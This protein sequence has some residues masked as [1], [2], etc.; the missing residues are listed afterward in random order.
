MVVARYNEPVLPLPW[1]LPADAAVTAYCKGRA[2]PA[3]CRV[4]RLPNVG[5]C[6]HT[7]LH[8][9]VTRYDSLA[10]VT[11]FLPGSWY[12]GVKWWLTW[13]VVAFAT[14][15]RAT[16]LPAAPHAGMDA[17]EIGTWHPSNPHNREAGPHTL[18]P[19][20]P[21]PFGRWFRA[22]F[23]GER[24]GPVVF[25]GIFAATA[26]DIRR[27]PRHFYEGL[28]RQLDHHPRPAAGHYCERAW[29]T[30]LSPRGPVRT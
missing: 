17:F 22:N 27:R 20:V 9:I 3:G 7:Y 4:V 28:L 18:L 21:S 5:L 24:L 14:A 30:I 19:A 12:Q 25:K 8:H 1:L 16:V 23:P 26:A 13:G 29:G 10:P 6:D 11:V 15:C 2:E